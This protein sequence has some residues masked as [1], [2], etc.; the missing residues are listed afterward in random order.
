MKPKGVKTI[1]GY[2]LDQLMKERGING[3]ELAELIGKERKT[4][5]RIKYSK[6]GPKLREAVIIA[7]YFGVSIDYLAGLTNIRLP[8]NKVPQYNTEKKPEGQKFFNNG[9]GGNHGK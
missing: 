1:F 5:Y 8:A 9:W 4:T 7:K 2:R 6:E 3:A